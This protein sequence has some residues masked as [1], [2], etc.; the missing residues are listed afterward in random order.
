MDKYS[1][2]KALL[3][4]VVFL[5]YIGLSAADVFDPDLSNEI[6][7]PMFALVAATAL[8]VSLIPIVEGEPAGRAPST[9]PRLVHYSI[10]SLSAIS[11]F[12]A[13]IYWVRSAGT[14]EQYLWGLVIALAITAIAGL[15]IALYATSR[16]RS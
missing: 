5:A 6:K 7:A 16:M 9:L 13:A 1:W 12:L 2:T 4:G 10:L 3:G 15:Q 8:C 14:I 11:S